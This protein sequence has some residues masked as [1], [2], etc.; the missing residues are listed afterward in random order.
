[1]RRGIQRVLRVFRL[2]NSHRS[3]VAAAYPT[4]LADSNELQANHLVEFPAY[5]GVELPSP[6]PLTK[7]YDT[8][9]QHGSGDP[10]YSELDSGDVLRAELES[11]LETQDVIRFYEG[12]KT[13]SGLYRS[14]PSYVEHHPRPS[15]LITY[16]DQIR[17]QTV[18]MMSHSR[19]QVH[20]MSSGTAPPESGINIYNV[21]EASHTCS[22]IYV[23]NYNGHRDRPI[24]EFSS[25]SYGGPLTVTAQASSPAPPYGHNT[26]SYPVLNPDQSSSCFQPSRN[27]FDKDLQIPLSTQSSSALNMYPLTISGL[28]PNSDSPTDQ[29]ENSEQRTRA[30]QLFRGSC[31]NGDFSGPEDSMCAFHR[32]TALPTTTDFNGAKSYSS[33][34]KCVPSSGT[35]PPSYHYSHMFD[36]GTQLPYGK[37]PDFLDVSSKNPYFSGLSTSHPPAQENRESR[38]CRQNFQPVNLSKNG[39]ISANDFAG[40][41]CLGSSADVDSGYSTSS[42]LWSA[43]PWSPTDISGA[44]VSSSSQCW[45]V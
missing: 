8:R 39:M 6:Q 41:G 24:A 26:D 9:E 37:P 13:D 7:Q 22:D 30:L 11:S 35:F 1:M 15:A 45:S 2:K 42:P 32:G 3:K 40:T 12:K 27:R 4:A 10:L 34:P 29:H 16:H 31:N 23:P 17:Q 5:R 28:V 14:T 33:I 20:E 19:V 44:S 18:G 36:H 21:A 25:T 38:A 43:D